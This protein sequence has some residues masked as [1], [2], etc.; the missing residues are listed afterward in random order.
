MAHLRIP[1]NQ[2]KKKKN[3]KVICELV[4]CCGNTIVDIFVV[5]VVLYVSTHSLLTFKTKMILLVVV[6]EVEVAFLMSSRILSAGN[7]KN[8]NEALMD[9]FLMWVSRFFVCVYI[10]IVYWIWIERAGYERVP[11]Y[12]TVYYNHDIL[13]IQNWFAFQDNIWHVMVN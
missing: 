11:V 12:Q 3:R 1:L 7:A 10:K 5:V 8:V 6:V 4:L 9:P 2:P 13:R